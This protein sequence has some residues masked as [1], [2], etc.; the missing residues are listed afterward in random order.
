VFRKGEYAAAY[1]GFEGK[2]DGVDLASWL[3]ERRVSKVDVVGIA[4][5]HC[6]RATALDAAH[7]GLDTTVLLDFTAGVA[8]STVDTALAQ[9]REAGVKLVGEPIVR[10]A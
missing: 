7:A 4:T 6:V 5:D 8:Q 1:S 2:A 9:L 10:D 3:R